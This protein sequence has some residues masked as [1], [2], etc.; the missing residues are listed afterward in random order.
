MPTEAM[1]E[2]FTVLRQQHP[3][4]WMIWE[5]EPDAAIVDRL[6][7]LNVTSI[8]FRPAGNRPATGD[9]LTVMQTNIEQLEQTFRPR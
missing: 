4:H 6:R 2:A 8:V 9:Y 1:W 3:A 7:T 5:E